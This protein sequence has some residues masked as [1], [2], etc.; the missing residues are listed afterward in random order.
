MAAVVTLM[1]TTIM[2]V[3]QRCTDRVSKKKAALSCQMLTAR[4]LQLKSLP[5]PNQWP[6]P[7]VT[8][9][10]AQVV[11]LMLCVA[12]VDLQTLIRARSPST[13]ESPSLGAWEATTPTLTTLPEEKSVWPWD[14]ESTCETTQISLVPPVWRVILEEKI[15]WPCP[16]PSSE[17]INL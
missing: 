1:S 9:R 7:F 17:S 4:Q 5:Q 11:T 3:S 10:M 16:R 15:R 8:N 13:Q 14:R 2:G 12:T 6:N